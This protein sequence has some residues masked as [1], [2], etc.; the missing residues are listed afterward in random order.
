MK[1]VLALAPLVLVGMTY[2]A[3]ALGNNPIIEDAYTA[4]PAPLVDGDTVYLYCGHDADD[5]KGFKMPEWLLYS[6][7]DM[8]NWTAHGAV[9]AP[10]RNYTWGRPDSAWAAQCVKRNGK[11]Y[12]YTTCLDKRRDWCMAIGVLVADRPE[13]PFVDPLGKPLFVRQPGDPYNGYDIDPTCLIDDD[14]QAWLYWGNPRLFCVKLNKDMISY[15]TSFGENGVM[16]F[17]KLKD[18]QEGP[19]AFKHGGRYYMAYASTCCPEGIGY[20][21]GPSPTGPWTYGGH[22]MDHDIRSSGNHPG[23]IE[24]KGK[25]WCFGFSYIR[26]RRTSLDAPHA[27]RR[28]VHVTEMTFEPDGKIR[29]IPWWADI[30]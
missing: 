6:S 22:I 9:A 16:L 12:L 19:W 23:I 8:T 14:G 21:Y 2:G 20:S 24:F 5:A 26:Y 29:Q 1:T 25:W 11:Y 28:S 3:S 7:K 17:P 27:E 30:R 13:G 15:D 18:Y 10:D 4:D